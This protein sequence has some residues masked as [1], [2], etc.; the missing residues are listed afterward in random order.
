[1]TFTARGDTFI[2]ERDGARLDSQYERVKAYVPGRDWTTLQQ[3]SRDTGYPEASV[4][5]RLR[6]LRARGYLVEHQYVMR[7]LW[8]YRVSVATPKQLGLV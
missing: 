5:A 1:M 3:I 4:S 2:P 7:G 8:K 6:D